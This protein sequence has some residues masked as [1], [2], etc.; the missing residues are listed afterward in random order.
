MNYQ[1]TGSGG[2]TKQIAEKT[3]DFGASDEPLTIEKLNK[4]CLIRFPAVISGVVPI[5][6]INGIKE[7]QL[8][9][10]PE[11]TAGIFAGKIT[12]WSDPAI[13]NINK[14]LPFQ[15]PR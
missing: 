4:V 7:N 8:I 9:L 13:K 1:A 12:N 14:A 10:T 15:T 5:V 3:T 11:I 6:N 2:G